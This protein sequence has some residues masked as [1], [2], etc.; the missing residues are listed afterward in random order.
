MKID[1]RWLGGSTLLLV[2][3]AV[4]TA[5]LAI[6]QAPQP[7]EDL[8]HPQGTN[9]G[10]FAFTGNCATLPRQPHQR[11]SRPLYAQP[12]HA[13]RGAREDHG[14]R[15]RPT[16]AKRSTEF[17]KR[18]VA[19]YVGGRPL[20]SLATGDK[21]TMKNACQSTGAVQ[22]VR[23]VRMERLGSRRRQHALPAN[24]WLDRG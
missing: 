3:F 24:A 22:A 21:S 7:T 18:V 9:A 5:S 13:R 6:A 23:R 10:I 19:V 16:R 12:P 8:A 1:R 14:R 17:Q 15:A 20:G 2:S 11:R 4:V